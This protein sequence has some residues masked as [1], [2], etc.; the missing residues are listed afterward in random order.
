MSI[1]SKPA[2]WIAAGQ[3]PADYEFSTDSSVRHGGQRSALV[4]ARSAR[5]AGFG[6]LMQII[7]ADDFRGRRVRWS[8]FIKSEQVEGWCGL[9]LRADDAAE[10]VLA[11]DSMQSRPVTGTSGWSSGEVV[12]DVPPETVSIAFGLVLDGPGAVWLDDVALE[13]VGAEVPTT[14]ISAA[15]LPSQP[16]NL[17]FEE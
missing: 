10:R 11:F 17:R 5:P 8:G 7:R 2:G 15:T 6:T 12:L 13:V 1:M 3:A 16:Q 9:W 4:R 14:K